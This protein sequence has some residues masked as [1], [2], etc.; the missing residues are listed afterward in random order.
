M[1]NGAPPLARRWRRRDWESGDNHTLIAAYYAPATDGRAAD[2]AVVVLHAGSEP[3]DVVVPDVDEGSIWCV[4]ADSAAPDEAS[5]ARRYDGLATV[6][7]AARSAVVLLE[8]VKQSETRGLQPETAVAPV[9]AEEAPL[10]APATASEPGSLITDHDLPSA[11]AVAGE[12]RLARAECAGSHARAG[13]RG[14]W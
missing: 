13:R 9:T 11:S 12:G 7:V 14:G 3:L 8:S 10:E 4:A 2:R 1:S 6:P 5:M